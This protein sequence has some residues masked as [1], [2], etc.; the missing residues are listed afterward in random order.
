MPVRLFTPAQA[1][2]ELGLGRT[3]FLALVRAGRIRCRM[4][5]GRIRIPAEALEEF[6]SALP[7][8]YERGRPVKG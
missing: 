7:E 4:L 2:N 8:G 6:A 3:K 1:A 5:D